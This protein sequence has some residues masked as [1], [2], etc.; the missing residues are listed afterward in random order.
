MLA[1]PKFPNV[2]DIIS[3]VK[4]FNF[5]LT[6]KEPDENPHPGEFRNGPVI[7]NNSGHTPPDASDVASHM[8]TFA[9][10]VTRLWDGDYVRLHWIHPFFNGNGRTARAFSYFLLCV[11]Y[12]GLLPGPSSIT[13]QIQVNKD[14][15]YK[16]LHDA[17]EGNLS[18]LESQTREYLRNQLQGAVT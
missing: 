5:L 3:L 18:P 10:E 12:G 9:E 4:E 17:D 13:A 7:I 1:D 2:R 15:H 14:D 6:D 16:A 8:E 11:K